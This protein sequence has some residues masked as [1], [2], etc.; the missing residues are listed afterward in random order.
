MEFYWN[1]VWPQEVPLKCIIVFLWIVAF[2]VCLQCFKLKNRIA[3]NLAMI[4][5]LG[6]DDKIKDLVKSLSSNNVNYDE[7]FKTFES[8]GGKTEDNELVFDHLK[9]IFDAG[10]KS[11]RLDAD[12]LVKNTIDKICTNVDTIKSC[13]SVFLV[14]GILGTLVGLA[15]SIGSF[16]GDSFNI[17]TV[18]AKSTAQELS[19]LFG[20]LRG[21][22]APSMWGVFLTIM[23]VILYTVLIQEKYINKLTDKL[24]TNTIKVW[25]PA[26]YPTDFQKGNQTMRKLNDT[27]QNADAINDG[28]NDLVQNLT[29]ANETVRA[30]ND[31]S[32]ALTNSIVKFDEGSNKILLFK[33]SI[34]DLS[35]RISEN[36][37]NYLDWVKRSIEEMDTKQ[38]KDT[39]RLLD[40][41]DAISKNFAMQNEQL[42]QIVNTL[43]LYDDN[44][45]KSQNELTSKLAESISN[46]IN[47][48]KEMR[49]VIGELSNKNQ[50]IIDEVG[51]PIYQQ[52]GL[53]S[54]QLTDSLKA[55]TAQLNQ[56]KAAM[57]R[58]DSP[59]RSTAEDIQ[60]MFGHMM[61][62]QAQK[63]D[64]I[65]AAKAG[66]SPEERE[67]LRRNAEASVAGNDNKA[68]EKKLDAILRCLERGGG[69]SQFGKEQ[70]HEKSVM[71]MVKECM[72]IAIGVL[73]VISIAVQCVMVS[74]IGSLEQSQN[75]VN[76]VLLKGDKAN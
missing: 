17:S 56:L 15:I 27:I 18:E 69:E 31:V 19:K 52:L 20:N 70:K 49:G 50:A 41:T 57:D 6:D 26:L 60:T 43:K 38:G 1:L 10:R 61:D 68:L 64:Q 47:A 74:R 40:Q 5:D 35:K 36:G 76:Q 65:L 9:A 23:Y 62:T 11:S 33:D 2:Y 58:I 42:Q 3:S 21:A 71:Y 25:L 48:A 55:M 22:F 66:L 73:L 32:A 24:T 12:L 30:I 34:E 37:S 44:V 72:P 7:V 16:S 59:L 28:A 53:M 29:E 45:L 75:A 13:I 8:T 39:K 54:N 4:E 46:N 67:L 14:I 63:F 51:K